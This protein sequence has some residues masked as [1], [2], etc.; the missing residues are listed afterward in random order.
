MR[1]RG[2][3]GEDGLRFDW[4]M[5]EGEVSVEPCVLARTRDLSTA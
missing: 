1:P 2:A 3:Q 4:G 5:W